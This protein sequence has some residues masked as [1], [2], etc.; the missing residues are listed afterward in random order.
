[1]KSSR[2]NIVDNPSA[3]MI[4]GVFLTFYPGVFE[5]QYDGHVIFID[6][7]THRQTPP[8]GFR[9]QS[10]GTNPSVLKIFPFDEYLRCNQPVAIEN[11][12]SHKTS[13][14]YSS[15][16]IDIVVDVILTA[17][18]QTESVFL[19]AHVANKASMF[20]GLFQCSSRKQEMKSIVTWFLFFFPDTD[21]AP[22]RLFLLTFFNV[23]DADSTSFLK[24]LCTIPIDKKEPIP[25]IADYSARELC[26]FALRQSMVVFPDPVIACPHQFFSVFS[27]IHSLISLRRTYYDQYTILADCVAS[28]ITELI[29][30]DETLANTIVSTASIPFFQ[31][32]AG[33]VGIN[34]RYRGLLV[35][36][37]SLYPYPN[38]WDD[39][40]GKLR[41]AP[42]IK[43]FFGLVRHQCTGD[44]EYLLD[45]FVPHLAV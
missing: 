19:P 17:T 39:F 42:D 1:M 11:F 25:F 7:S 28:D 43:N 40:R 22:Q 13:W 30:E 26:K 45:A 36:Q 31:I 41:L 6:P 34:P 3:D 33:S 29:C 12:P 18:E 24:P 14:N 23:T 2:I 16:L 10:T 35:P 20:P 8:I 5:P 38:F 37:T 21:G 44:L 4:G 15:F 32:P 9:Q 27:V